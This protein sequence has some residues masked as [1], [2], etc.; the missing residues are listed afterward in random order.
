MENDAIAEGFKCILEMHG[1][2]YRTVI[3][4]GDSSVYQTIVDS[5]PYREQ[6]VTVKKIECT[7]H[8]LRNL[9]K[10]LRAV[11]ETTQQK[12]HRKCSFVHLRNVV[13]TNILKIRKEVTK[14]I[15][16]RKEEKQP[17]H[18]K[19][20]EQKDILNIPGHIFGE[21]K[22]CKKRGRICDYDETKKNYVP[23]LKLHGL[24]QKVESAIVYLSGYSDS[25]LLKFTN[26][27]AESFNSIICKEIG[28]K[29]INFGNRGSYNARIAGAIVQYNT[30]QVLTQVHKNMC[31][32]VLPI[33]ETLEKR[34]VKV[35]RSRESRE[36]NGRQKKLKR[37]SG[38]DCYYGSNH[39]NRIF[40]SMFLS[41]TSTKSFGKV[42]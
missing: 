34:Q 30:Q 1:M 26:N 29:R 28:G 40:H 5:K 37:E 36:I 16:L 10:K 33:V 13:K 9:C 35:A 12:M 20:M 2:I 14:A 24:Y 21:H 6:M 22:Q 11:A 31:E 25:L 42:V 41:K 18:Y 17:D 38:T 4:D 3:A 27:P 39:K 7:N 19:A 8:L 23:F 32:N 15:D